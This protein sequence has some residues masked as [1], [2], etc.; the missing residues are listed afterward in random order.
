MPSVYDIKDEIYSK[1]YN[2]K[3]HGNYKNISESTLNIV[4]TIHKGGKTS[5]PLSQAKEVS[6]EGTI[7]WIV[8]VG[9]CVC[10]C[11]YVFI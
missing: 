5:L 9:V 4:P 3:N 7:D 8:Y 11:M 10:A 6:P 2:Q 1:K